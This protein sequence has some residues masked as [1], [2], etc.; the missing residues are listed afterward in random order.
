MLHLL[1]NINFYCASWAY[2]TRKHRNHLD[3][4]LRAYTGT[5]IQC[6]VIYAAHV[7]KIH[8]Q[9][10]LLRRRTRQFAFSLAWKKEPF[11]HLF[12]TRAT[13]L[14][15]C[16]LYVSYVAWRCHIDLLNT[17]C[18]FFCDRIFEPKWYIVFIN[19]CDADCWILFLSRVWRRKAATSAWSDMVSSWWPCNRNVRE[20]E[21]V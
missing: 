16:V 18:S 15:H 14:F 6:R 21:T 11:M 8:L 5:I 20:C 10:L 3:L 17:S 1:N 12:F 7:I 9:Y 13:L 19:D 2:C 4:N